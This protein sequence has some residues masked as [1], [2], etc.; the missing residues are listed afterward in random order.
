M[1]LIIEIIVNPRNLLYINHR[2]RKGSKLVGKKVK[3]TLITSFVSKNLHATILY[4][5]QDIIDY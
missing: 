3:H 1:V 4:Y 5:Y 2:F